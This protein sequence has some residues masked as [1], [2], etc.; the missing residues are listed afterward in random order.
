MAKVTKQAWLICQK[1]NPSVTK[2]FDTSMCN[3]RWEVLAG[4]VDVTFDVPDVARCPH[5]NGALP[6]QETA[7]LPLLPLVVGGV[8]RTRNEG[9]ATIFSKDGHRTYPWNDTLGRSYT[10]DG[11]EQDWELSD[12]D[13]IER[14]A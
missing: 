9:R 6:Q 12:N 11:H 1:D 7:K 4:P 5:C 8:Y 14:I 2:L 10:D 3:D 13:L